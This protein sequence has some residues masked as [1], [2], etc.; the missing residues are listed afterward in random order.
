MR[1][2]TKTSIRRAYRV[3]DV[4]L[5]HVA[6]GQGQ[7]GEGVLVTVSAAHATTHSQ[8]EALRGGR[9]NKTQLL[10]PSTL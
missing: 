1:A 2:D 6:Q 10:R 5:V 3:E 7:G 9:S 4:I 8:V